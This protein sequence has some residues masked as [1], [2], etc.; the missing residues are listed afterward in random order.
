MSHNRFDP[1]FY[2]RFYANPRTRVTTQ[3]EMK[4]RAAAIAVLVAHLDVPVKRILDAGC[5]LGWMRGPLLEAFPGAVYVGLEVSEHLCER[6][7]WINESVAT[8]KSRSGFDLVICYDVLQYLAD[9]E[10]R[11]AL[12][13]LGRLC[14]GAL[15]FHAPTQ[16]D[17][18]GNA[19]LDVSDAD[20][21]LR[22]ADWYRQRLARGF[23]PLGFG[24]H[25]R[26]GVPIVR[27][28]LEN[29]Q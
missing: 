10:A 6:L 26:K 29:A 16:E 1:A 24:M 18:Q 12:A 17:W 22:D 15:Y 13:N 28:E 11:R 27:W 4:R 25:V 7:G 21:H 23:V 3:A 2:Q 20:I 8:Y 14:R 19:D 9:R 5:G